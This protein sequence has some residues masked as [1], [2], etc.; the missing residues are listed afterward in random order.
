MIRT[1]SASLPAPYPPPSS[2]ERQ[3][4]MQM[5]VHL[6]QRCHDTRTCHSDLSR[7]GGQDY[8]I[9]PRVT[10]PTPSPRH[11]QVSQQ[12]FGVAAF[13][14]PHGGLGPAYPNSARGP[15][16]HQCAILDGH[17]HSR[18]RVQTVQTQLR[19]HGFWITTSSE[20]P[21]C[22]MFTRTARMV[23]TMLFRQS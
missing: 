15:S 1:Q 11:C 12:E 10:R 2:W 20:F 9:F 19:K 21:I 16:Q 8:Q 18:L 22:R 17:L 13:R 6:G 3:V 5:I 14:D 23:I 4:R 7:D